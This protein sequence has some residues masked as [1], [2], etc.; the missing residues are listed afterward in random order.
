MPNAHQLFSCQIGYE[1]VSNKDDRRIFATWKRHAVPYL[2]PAVRA[3]S[4]LDYLSIAQHH[5]LATRLFDW[6]FNALNAAFFALVLKQAK[7]QRCAF[8]DSRLGQSVESPTLREGD[9][10]FVFGVAMLTHLLADW[11]LDAAMDRSIRTPASFP[12]FS[13]VTARTCGRTPVATD[14]N[15]GIGRSSG[16]PCE[17]SGRADAETRSRTS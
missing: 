9:D 5:G 6:T 16:G 11:P 3:L 1:M 2:D 8:H 14:S 4:E 12:P 7:V 13:N 15:S 17:R 10:R